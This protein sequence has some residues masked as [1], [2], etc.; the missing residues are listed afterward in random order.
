V[1]F[2]D[3]GSQARFTRTAAL[4]RSLAGRLQPVVSADSPSARSGARGSA[5]PKTGGWS[6]AGRKR[7]DGVRQSLGGSFVVAS[8]RRSVMERRWLAC[9]VEPRSS[10]GSQLQ[11]KGQLVGGVRAVIAAGMFDR[12]GRSAGGRGGESACGILDSGVD[13]DICRA[14]RCHLERSP[15]DECRDV[16]ARGFSGPGA[17]PVTVRWVARSRT[18]RPPV[19]SVQVE[20]EQLPPPPPRSDQGPRLHV[21]GFRRSAGRTW[22]RR[23]RSLRAVAAAASISR[24]GCTESA[25]AKKRRGNGRGCDVS[26]QPCR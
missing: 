19:V 11:G 5:A 24:V 4:I 9:S 3:S 7:L 18:N 13:E 12:E 14:G 15:A 20:R 21:P 23:R 6:N 25:A 16:P 10:K 17:A 2:R 8:R 22:R 26:P 1:V